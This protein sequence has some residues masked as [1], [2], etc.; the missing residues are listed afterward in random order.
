[1]R[2]YD[3][4]AMAETRRRHP[5]NVVYDTG[6]ELFLGTC[7]SRGVGGVGVLVNTT[8]TSKYDEEEVEAFYMDMKKYYRE[9]HTFF[10]VNIGDFNAKIG[11][12]RTS[13]ERHIWNHGL[14]WNEQGREINMMNDLAAEMSRR[15]RA[16]W[17][18]FKSIE[19]VAKRIKNT[20]LR[21]HLFDSTVLLGLTYISK[22]TSKLRPELRERICQTVPEFNS[23]SS[24]PYVTAPEYKMAIKV[25]V[26]NHQQ[27]LQRR[28]ASY[29]GLINAAMPDSCLLIKKSS[30]S[31]AQIK[32]ENLLVFD[33]EDDTIDLHGYSSVV[34]FAQIVLVRLGT[35]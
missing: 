29:S 23:T 27:V 28:N 34:V 24:K 31:H 21:A 16:A 9:D 3:V 11:P 10:K 6:E 26:H 13:E 35:L 18:A 25:L 33:A 7:V 22:V 5:I 32:I 19:D 4:I 20:R 8:L 2:I 1:M 15:K 14:E 17:G 12:R 30:E